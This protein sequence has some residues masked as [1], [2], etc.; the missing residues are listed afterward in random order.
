MPGTARWGL[1]DMTKPSAQM[2][3][4][5]KILQWVYA[6]DSDQGHHCVATE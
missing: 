5:P 6:H 1:K 3:K 4:A 2:I